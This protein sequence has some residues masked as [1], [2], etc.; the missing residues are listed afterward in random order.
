MIRW[1]FR[2]RPPPAPTTRAAKI[3]HDDAE[4][5]GSSARFAAGSRP[6]VR[7]DV[8]ADTDIGLQRE[9]IFLTTTALQETCDYALCS[10]AAGAAEARHM[11]ELSSQP[12]EWRR[13]ADLAPLARLRPGAPEFV[14]SGPIAIE[15]TGDWFDGWVSG[16]RLG[17]HAL[18][19]EVL[20]LAPEVSE[21]RVAAEALPRLELEQLQGMRRLDVAPQRPIPDVVARFAW[22]GGSGQ[23]G[24]PGW[25]IADPLARLVVERAAPFAGRQVLELGTSRGRLAAMLA[26]I[27]CS[28]TTVDHQ[29]RGARTNL[30]GLPVSVI[31]A[32]LVRFLE[33]TAQKFDL[34]VCD[35]HGNSLR[36]W[37]RYR[38]PLLRAMTESAVLILNNAA[39]HR[40]EGWETETG[41]P[42][43]LS[44]LPRRWLVETF[45]DVLPGISVVT[46]R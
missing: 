38:K 28:V 31:Q 21:Q 18:Q 17:R 3:A 14:L 8:P 15:E 35:L 2:N 44:T 22:L 32:D 13:M 43:F 24:V 41:V 9:A 19:P 20:A 7:W 29:D 26:S 11:L 4:F 34:I 16:Q 33:G 37:R 45:S 10:Q 40:L 30:E 23:W 25:S 5:D 36:E 27:G 42:W 46:S 6:L 39:L 1:P 12:V